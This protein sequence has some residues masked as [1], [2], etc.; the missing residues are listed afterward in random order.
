[1]MNHHSDDELLE[2][3]KKGHQRSFDQLFRKYYKILV[4]SAIKF[5]IDKFVAEELVQDLF[6]SLWQK[7]KNLSI[8]G[9]LK[10]YL[11]V[12][13]KNRSLNYL[14]SKYAQKQF[15]ELTELHMEI[16]SEETD[17]SEI[18]E[19]INKG[20]ERLPEKCKYVFVLSRRA[21]LSYKEI[22]DELNISIKTV[23]T[24]MGIALKRLREFVTEHEKK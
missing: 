23:E 14:K 4:L 13:I 24:Q 15:V 11:L 19:I 18:K 20:I 1:M 6:L 2:Q 22:A 3:M 17:T 21:G 10:N 5:V 9:S 7:R 12:A 8:L 16:L